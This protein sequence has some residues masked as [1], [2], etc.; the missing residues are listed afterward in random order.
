[1][2]RYASFDGVGIAYDVIGH[3]P[4]VLLHH[5]FASNSMINWVR[6]GVAAAIA[7]AGYQVVLMDARGHGKSDKP[8][9]PAAYANDAMVNDVRALFDVLAIDEVDVVG[10]SLGSMVALGLAQV[11]PRTRSMVLGGA[12]LGQMTASRRDSMIRIAEALEASDR[13]TITDATGQAFRNFADATGAD[14]IALAALQ[15]ADN[16]VSGL[17]SLGSIAVPTLV[18]NG[19]QDTLVGGPESL[20]AAIPHARYEL[21]PGDHLSAVVKP[22]FRQAVVTFLHSL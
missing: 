20:A 5:G 13:G 10:Y 22:E 6:P 9:E 18:V 7:V 11:E 1:V 2:N 3:G 16:L 4:A 15:R 21:V 8:H 17:D 19:E 14:R 12:G